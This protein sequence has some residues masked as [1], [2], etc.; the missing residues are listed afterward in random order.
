MGMFFDDEALER[1]PKRE[2]RPANL[3]SLQ[4]ARKDRRYLTPAEIMAL[5]VGSGVSNDIELAPNYFLAGFKHFDTQTYFKVEAS[6]DNGYFIDRELLTAIMFRFKHYGFNIFGYDLP[7]LEAAVKGADIT[8]LRGISNEIIFGGKNY[9]GNRSPWNIV[10]LIEVAPLKGGLKLYTARIHAPRIQELH[11][12]FNAPIASPEDAALVCD[13]NGNDLDCTEQLAGELAPHIALREKI[14]AKYNVDFR[15]LSDAQFGERILQFEIEAVGGKI[16]RPGP[17]AYIGERFFYRPPAYIQFLTPQLQEALEKIAR[18]VVVVD[19]NGYCECP[20]L[21][22][23]LNIGGRVYAMGLGGLHS[24]EECQAVVADDLYLIEDN[25][26]T[27]YY[28]NLIL[29]N[30][31]ASRHL[32]EIEI[33]AGE[34]IVTQR[35]A[36]KKGGDMVTADSLKIACNGAWFGKKSDPYS[37]MYDPSAMLHTTLTGQLS[38]LMAIEYLTMQGFEVISANTDGIVCR[39]LRSRYDEFRATFK[40]WEAHTGLETEATE[41]SAVY[42]RDVNNYIAVKP[43][44]KCKTKGVYCERGSALNSPLSK[45]PEHLVCSEAVQAFLTKGTPVA[46]FIA[47]CQDIRKFVCIKNVSSPGAHKEGFYLGK[48][49]RWYYA[50]GERSAIYSVKSGNQVSKSLGARPLMELAG[51]PADLDRDWYVKEAVA[52]LHRIGYYQAAKQQ[53]LL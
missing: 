18:T 21:D 45:N 33:I 36:A 6:P 35:Y 16:Q 25:D 8:G 30:K 46:E 39:V 24:Q 17:E 19:P 4:Y 3:K 13:Y 28:P 12:D 38:L 40:A 11:T 51:I 15:S 42:S 48:V 49:V 1:V 43:D 7:I 27:G 2:R 31:F 23:E 37:I 32:G 47:N 10:D 50:K 53:R 9:Y 5:P 52:I 44:G 14:S 26:V 20:D 29:K 34:K 41:Y 22:I